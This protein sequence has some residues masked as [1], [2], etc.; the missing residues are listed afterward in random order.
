MDAETRTQQARRQRLREMFW[1]YERQAAGGTFEW[2]EAIDEHANRS[3][4]HRA[5]VDHYAGH[6]YRPRGQ[7]GTFDIG[8]CCEATDFLRTRTSAAGFRPELVVWA[9]WTSEGLT[10]RAITR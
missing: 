6:G 10:P 1:L 4:H 5:F 2:H 8:P 9:R 3:G 7:V